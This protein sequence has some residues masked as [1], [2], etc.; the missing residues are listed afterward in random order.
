[1][2]EPENYDFALEDHISGEVGE[3]VRS[4][5]SAAESAA[6]VIRHEAEQEIAGRKRI[7]EQERSRYLE[8]ARHEA[9]ELLRRRLQRMTELSEKLIEGADRLLGQMDSA[10]DLRRQLD[11]TVSA[12][13]QAAE[14]LAVEEGTGITP[15]EARPVEPAPGAHGE[16]EAEVIEDVEVADAEEAPAEPPLRAAPEPEPEPEAAEAAGNGARVDSEDDDVLAARLVALQMAVAGCPRGEV[17]EHLRSNFA[18]EDTTS[19]LND[20]FGSDVP[21]LR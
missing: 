7:A 13:A 4:I 21:R 18:V 2:P 15:S 12:L 1:V 16:P 10:H 9:D 19:I 14:R 3:R 8:T 17:E 20:V 6:E 11:R 5:L